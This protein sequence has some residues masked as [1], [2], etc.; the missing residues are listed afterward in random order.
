MLFFKKKQAGI[1]DL[2]RR[3]FPQLDITENA[4]MSE[5]TTFRCGGRAAALATPRSREELSQLLAWLAGPAAPQHF[6]L[7]NG[8]N[9]LFADGLYDGVVIK[10]GEAFSQYNIVENTLKAG[11]GMLL[12]A[13]AKECCRRGL[14]GLEFATGIPGSVGGGVF[15][16]AGAYSS[17][18]SAVLRSATTIDASGVL[19]ERTAEELSLGYRHSA[20]MDSG[21]I[22]LEA[23]FELSPADQTWIDET[24]RDLTERRVSKQPLQYP[25][26]GSFFRRP[27]GHF[28]GALIEGSGL[29]GLRIGGAQVSELHAGFII[30]AGGATAS[31]VIDLMR[32]VQETVFHD[33]GVLLE[34]EVRII[35]L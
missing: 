19:H 32:V 13:A 9:V 10:I 28:A 27:E 33:S 18:I 21:E 14:S 22:V 1:A 4:Q 24:V 2:L 15:M 26:A 29:K 34:P 35:G 17:D 23:S 5:H 8:S 3:Q 7:G 25:S 31:D 11:S 12:A 16:N 20:L 30:N 6:V